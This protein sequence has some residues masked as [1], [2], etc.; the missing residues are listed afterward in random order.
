M[1]EAEQVA[2]DNYVELTA[3]I[4]SAY[5]SNNSMLPGELPAL[6]SSIHAA[7]SGV[8]SGQNQAVAGPERVTPAQIKKSVTPDY[9]ISFEDGKQYKTLKRHLTLRGLTAEEYRAKWGLPADYPMTSANYSA[10]RSQ[11]AKE[12]GLGQQRRK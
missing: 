12:L 7:L 8:A 4:V 10:Q 1:S 3:E 6:I 2:Q 11:L 5:V 9:L